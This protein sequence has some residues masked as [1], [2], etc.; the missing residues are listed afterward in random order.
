MSVGSRLDLLLNRRHRH[1]PIHI[2]IWK[3]IQTYTLTPPRE[4]K[5][6]DEIKK[7]M[8]KQLKWIPVNHFV[9]Y[10]WHGHEALYKKAYVV[11]TLYIMHMYTMLIVREVDFCLTLFR[12]LLSIAGT[13]LPSFPSIHLYRC[14][15]FEHKTKYIIFFLRNRFIRICFA[16]PW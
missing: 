7:N 15:T 9:R 5:R 4:R 14:D 3:H 1:I 12:L 6:D 10:T 16:F 8:W 2:W 13:S 11:Y